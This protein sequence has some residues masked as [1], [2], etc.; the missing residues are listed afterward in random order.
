MTFSII[1]PAYN[2]EKSIQSIIER[3]QKACPYIICETGVDEVEIIVV[4]DGSSDETKEFAQTHEGIQLISYEINRGYG[5]A[6]KLGFKKAKGE[7]LGFLDADGTCD[8]RFFSML[9][10]SLIK[11]EADIAIGSRLGSDSQMPRIRRFGNNIYAKIINFIG[12]VRIT[13]SASGMRVLK[14]KTLGD[15]YPLPDGMHFTPAMSCKALMNGKLKIIEEPMEYKEREGRSK[16]SVIRDGRQFLKTII[17]ISLYYRPFK[18]FF[19][20]GSLL[21]IMALVYAVHPVIYYLAYHRIEE[22]FIYRLISIIVFSLIGVNFILFGL[23]AQN[24]LCIIYNKSDML[25]RINNKFFKIL[26]YPRNLIRT[27]AFISILG[28]VLN[29]QTIYQYLTTGKI[30]LHWVYVLTGAFLLMMGMEIFTFGF[31]QK[32]LNMHKEHQAFLKN[33]RGL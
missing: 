26:L 20:I 11:N 1:I 29:W 24:F 23:F 12:S 7:I 22:F 4:N 6:I 18:I 2:E 32:I 31:L 30:F 28:I 3:T 10:N 8:P 19:L 5:A 15:L 14:R 9:I 27:G 17:E 16:L 25:D 21:I 13:D 33:M